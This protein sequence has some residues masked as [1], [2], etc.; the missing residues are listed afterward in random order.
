MFPSV[1]ADAHMESDKTKQPDILL[2]RSI[3][4]TRRRCAALHYS[5]GRLD[6]S[7]EPNGDRHYT[8]TYLP[9]YVTRDMKQQANLQCASNEVSR[10]GQGAHCSVLKFMEQHEMLSGWT[11]A[12]VTNLKQFYLKRRQRGCRFSVCA[13]C[14]TG[15]S[16][17]MG[18]V[19]L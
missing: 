14:P 5:A 10:R 19:S 15:H 6:E 13:C 11:H 8:C 16:S 18:H 9:K 7:R 3:D 1:A 2:L 4:P 17:S 12:L